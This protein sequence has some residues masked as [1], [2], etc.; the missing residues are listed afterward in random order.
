MYLIL[1]I[2]FLSN[3]AI[4]FTDRSIVKLNKTRLMITKIST[5]I[6]EYTSLKDL[7]TSLDNEFLTRAYE[8]NSNLEALQTETTSSPKKREIK[9]NAKQSLI[10]NQIISVYALNNFENSL[11]KNHSLE[12]KKALRNFEPW[13]LKSKQTHIN[14]IKILSIFPIST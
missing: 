3:F 2:Y 1:I 10:L 11:C 9:L 6:S 14:S 7:N 8:K 13:A 4:C 5:K 12:Y